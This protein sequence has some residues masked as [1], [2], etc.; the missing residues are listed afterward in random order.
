MD[1]RIC[2]RMRNLPTE[3]EPY[4]QKE[5]PSLRHHHNPRHPPIPTSRH[6]SNHGTTKMSREGCNSHHCRPRMLTGSSVSTLLHNCYGTRN[7]GTIPRQRLQ[8]VWNPHKN[9]QR[10]RSSLHVPLRESPL[11]KARNSTELI[12]GVPPPN[13]VVSVRTSGVSQGGRARRLS[14]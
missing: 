5:N 4:S 14:R 8:M 7:S 10:P 3:Q 9:H 6:R 11:P 2:Q 12:L 1:C 13:S